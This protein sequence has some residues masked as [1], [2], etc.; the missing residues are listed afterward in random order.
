MNSARHYF[1]VILLHKADAIFMQPLLKNIINGQHLNWPPPGRQNGAEFKLV[2][3]CLCSGK[4][5][6]LF[7]HQM[8]LNQRPASAVHAVAKRRIPPEPPDKYV[9]GKL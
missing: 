1:T 2:T 6:P 8:L 7:F 3:G 9:T 4:A 5:L